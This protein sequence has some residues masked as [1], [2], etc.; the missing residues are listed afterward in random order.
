MEWYSRI[1]PS[2][3]QQWFYGWRWTADWAA[4]LTVRS[5]LSDWCLRE[6]I[7]TGRGWW[8]TSHWPTSSAGGSW[9]SGLGQSLG[10]RR[11]SLCPHSQPCPAEIAINKKI[12][13]LMLNLSMVVKNTMRFKCSFCNKFHYYSDNALVV[14]LFKSTLSHL[15]VGWSNVAGKVA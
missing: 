10:Q 11:S 2:V 4:P 6:R 3:S 15:I 1:S 9:L 5:P 14:H 13:K 12:D 8:W 7:L